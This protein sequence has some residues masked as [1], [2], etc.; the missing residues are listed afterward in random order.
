MN[1]SPIPLCVDLDGSLVRTDTLYESILALIKQSPWSLLLL[2]QWLLRGKAYFKSQIAQRVSLNYALLPYHE[3]FLRW[4]QIQEQQ[5]RELV[6]VTAAD[7]KIATGVAAHLKI[8]G[9]VLASDGE[10]NLSGE[11]KRARLTELFGD[12]RYDYAG[13]ERT[14]IPV[15]RSA[16]EAV[17]I[18]S[19]AALIAAAGKQAV[20]SKTFSGSSSSLMTWLKALR[21]HQWVKNLLVFLPLLLSHKIMALP[22]LGQ[23]LWA[24]L[25]FS[26]CASSVY[27]LNDLLDLEADRQHPR[28]RLRPFASGVLELRKGIWLAPVLLVMA[29]VVALNLPLQFIAVLAVY[30]LS[31]LLYSL[32]LKHLALIDVMTLAG[33]YTLR[34]I[35][36]AAATGIVPSFWLLAFGMSIFLSLGITKRFTELTLVK[37]NGGGNVAVRGYL[38]DD[39]PLLRNLGA[40][41]GYSSVLVLA[42]YINSS[43]SQLLYPQ[44]YWLWL[45]CP[46]LLYWISRVWL[47]AHRGRM[48]DDPIVFALRDRVSMIVVAL[49][50]GAVLLAS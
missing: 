6:L 23:A 39:L 27:I 11:R 26:L 28:K 1:P 29:F 16:R 48:H 24:F 9:L 36:G 14:D 19:D 5:Q 35:A 41:A 31:T 15:W 34:I 44:P 30:Y 2:P 21:L 10:E 4:L 22:L 12:K 3:E 37:N 42:L 13:N 20:V 45:L 46:L 43:A 33:L 17:V 32:Y 8:F 38:A 7:Q 18:S 40:S 49:M 47:L 50:I 25:A